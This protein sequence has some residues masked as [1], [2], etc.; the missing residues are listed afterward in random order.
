MTGAEHQVRQFQACPYAEQPDADRRIQ[1]VTGHREQVH[2]QF[3]D[4]YRDLAHRLRG[5]GVH[6]GA[7]GARRGGNGGDRLHRPGLVVG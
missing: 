7:G 3:V 6:D 5:I 2:A 1:L 4:A